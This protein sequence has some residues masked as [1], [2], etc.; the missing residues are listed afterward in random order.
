M[1]NSEEKITDE[2]LVRQREIKEEKE[3]PLDVMEDTDT[4]IFELLKAREVPRK[5]KVY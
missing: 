1:K 5:W 3:K 4:P 2:A